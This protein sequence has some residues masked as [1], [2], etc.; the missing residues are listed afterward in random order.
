MKRFLLIDDDKNEVMY[1]KFLFRDRYE[2]NFT[3]D[4]VQT[5]NDAQSYLSTTGVDTI[6]LDDK[7]GNGL[8]SVDTI[9]LLN[10]KAFNVP[11][12]VISKDITAKHLRDRMRLGL[13]KVID[14]FDL[15]AQL[16]NGV[17]D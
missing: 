6:L 7:L 9:P 3:L 16:A 12:I 11:I 14:K 8:T 15:K 1:V 13:N 2:D 10:K 17:F 5:L 4:H